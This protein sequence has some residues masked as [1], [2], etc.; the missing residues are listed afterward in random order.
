MEEGVQEVERGTDEAS[1]SGHA[2][3]DI[4]EQINAVSMQVNQI[5]TATE[6]QTVT[7]NEITNNIQ[8]IM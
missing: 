2:L 3:E 8:Q 4:L 5:A 1:K 7:T 6:E